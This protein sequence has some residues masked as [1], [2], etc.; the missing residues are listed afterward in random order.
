MQRRWRRRLAAALQDFQLAQ[1]A[2]QALAPPAQRLVDRFGRR[3]EASLQDGQREP[4]RAR[5]LVVLERLG[6][7]ELLAHVVGDFLVERASAS[8]SLYGTV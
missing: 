3:R 6:A 8:D 4:N 5:A 7:I 2:F 1:P